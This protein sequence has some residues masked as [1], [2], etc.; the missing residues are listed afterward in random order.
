ML[1]LLAS[2]IGVRKLVVPAGAALPVASPGENELRRIFEA[3][4]LE[5]DVS[6]V[7]L[8][9]EVGGWRP[10]SMRDMRLSAALNTGYLLR[11]AL[12]RPRLAELDENIG[13]ALGLR[14]SLEQVVRERLDGGGGGGGGAT[15]GEPFGGRILAFVR[16]TGV[17]RVVDRFWWQ[18]AVHLQ[19]TWL[20]DSP[21]A[22]VRRYAAGL[23]ASAQ[24]DGLAPFEVSDGGGGGGGAGGQL[25]E[26]VSIAD[27]VS[28]GTTGGK[29]RL[30]SSLFRKCELVEPTFEQVLLIWRRRPPAADPPRRLLRDA[31]SVLVGRRRG[32]REGA[33]GQR[34]RSSPPSSLPSI[35]MEIF[36]EVPMANLGVV[37]PGSRVCTAR[38]QARAC[39]SARRTRCGSTPLPALRPR[40]VSSV[41][42]TPR[43]SLEREARRSIETGGARLDVDGALSDLLRMRVVASLTRM[44]GSAE[45]AAAG[46]A[47][48][49][50]AAGEEAALEADGA[51]GSGNVVGSGGAVAAAPPPAGYEWGAPDTPPDTATSSSA[52]RGDANGGSGTDGAG[53]GS[54]WIVPASAAA[55]DA[56]LALHWSSLL[57]PRAAKGDAAAGELWAGRRGRRLRVLNFSSAGAVEGGGGAAVAEEEE[58]SERDFAVG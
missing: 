44:P 51:E 31:L 7:R 47:G 32:E 48:A 4:T 36:E 46:E 24:L 22:A 40:L 12:D 16:G 19:N 23:N 49:G 11:V 10:L 52:G 57:R 56:A 20:S 13:E 30:A 33:L 55:A 58:L 38:R 3:E 6:G 1:L 42:S 17:E 21:L 37:L 15:A 41:S 35:E 27:E 28:I 43:R 9:L 54:A 50:T 25:V 18:K 2:S 8:W 34:R 45:A 39:A 14:P 5:M 53:D 26:R 29:R